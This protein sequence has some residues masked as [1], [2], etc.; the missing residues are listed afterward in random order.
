MDRTQYG[1]GAELCEHA[2][3]LRAAR[4][5]PG[6][7]SVFE[8]GHLQGVPFACERREVLRSGVRAETAECTGRGVRR[9]V[10]LL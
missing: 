3:Q 10:G 7:Q 5:V 2:V 8:A 9:H 4:R 1:D 6:D